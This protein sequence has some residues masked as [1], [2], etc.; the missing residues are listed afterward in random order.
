MTIRILKLRPLLLLS[1]CWFFAASP[2][3]SQ[4]HFPAPADLEHMLRYLVEDGET[5]GAVL[6]ILE[7]DGSTKVVSYGSAGA[8]NG[9][10][11]PGSIFEIGSITKT[12]TA[13]VLADMVERG[14]VALDDPLSTYLPEDL[15]V[16]TFQGREITLLDLATHRSGLPNVP[17]DLQVGRWEPPWFDYT[18][19]DA[20]EFIAKYEVPRPPGSEFEY[21]NIGYGLL[22]H[23]LGRAAGTGFR[24]LVRTRVLEPLGMDATGFA[25]VKD[26]TEGST[27]GHRS[28]VP[29][30]YRTEVGILD[31]AGGLSSSVPDLIEYLKANVGP[32][33]TDLERAMQLAQEIRYAAG[34]EGGGQGLAWGTSV[35]PGEAAMVGHAGGTVGY[36]ARLTFLPSLGTGMVL[37]TNDAEFD[38][39]IATN[40]LYPDPPPA[41]WRRMEV[42][43]QMVARYS[44]QYVAGSS[45]YYIRPDLDG[46][47]T[48]QPEGRVR[49]RLYPT[50]DT[51]FY[52][53][54]GPW[55]FT[56]RESDD[57]PIRIVMTI[58]EREPRQAGGTRTATKV[59]DELPSSILAAGNADFG[60]RWGAGLWVLLGLLGVT[61]GA[62]AARAIWS[63]R[64]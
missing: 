51:T 17:D 22:G 31:A 28:G 54:R 41:N 60:R 24:E 56:F 33:D 64:G 38:D 61:T 47:L 35:F 62:F 63:R 53:L 18:V 4:H 45:R 36:S 14:E 29:A 34:E 12:F 39:D 43:P 7:S 16:P 20:Y 49:A 9:P 48:Y 27:R 11:G 1:A 6:G 23:A 59:S 3:V 46:A 19:E 13:T 40:L 52:M 44:G 55:S 50:S 5:S 30:R 26:R 10:I 21:S 15:I 57:A 32:P 37:L 2:A 58:D 42:S 25:S 8:D